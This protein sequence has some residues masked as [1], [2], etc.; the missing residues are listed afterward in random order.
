MKPY[1]FRSQ[2]P[3]F[4]PRMLSC[5]PNQPRAG[6]ECKTVTENN[7]VGCPIRRSMDHGLFS[8]SHGLSQSITSF[9]ASYCQGIHQTPFSRLIR[10]RKSKAPG[11]ARI[12]DRKSYFPAHPLVREVDIRLVYLTWTKLLSSSKLRRSRTRVTSS[13]DVD[14]S[15]RCQFVRLDGS[16]P[17]GIQRSNRHSRLPL[18]ARPGNARHGVCQRRRRH[19]NG[20]SRRT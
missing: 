2:V 13:S 10:S 20:G 9:I 4:A 5:A 18:R 14:L 12:P 19:Q 3:V 16:M 17:R 11:G 1:V 8:A 15:L 6:T 7:Q